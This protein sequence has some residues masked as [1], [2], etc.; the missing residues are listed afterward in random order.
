[1]A[2]A[3]SI[4]STA[5]PVE[6]IGKKRFG[7]ESRQAA[8][9]RQSV[10][11]RV[12]KIGFFSLFLAVECEVVH[13]QASYKIGRR[14]RLVNRSPE[15]ASQVC[16]PRPIEEYAELPCPFTKNSPQN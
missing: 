13:K 6:P 2:L 5:G 7:S 12:I 14:R 16:P 8:V 10:T 3:A 4:W 11:V 1:M 15:S 9:S